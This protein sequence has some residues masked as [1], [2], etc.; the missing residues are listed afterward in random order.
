MYSG[1]FNTQTSVGLGELHIQRDQA[2]GS[3][4][5]TKKFTFPSLGVHC[6]AGA[7][8]V[9]SMR[10]YTKPSA[11]DGVFDTNIPGI[12]IRLST[13]DGPVPF[14]HY[15]DPSL[16]WSNSSGTIELIKT[17]PVT[18]SGDL[19]R[20]IIFHWGV[21]DGNNAPETYM[22][23]EWNLTSGRIIKLACALKSDSGLAFNIGDAPS[24]QF[25]SK[26][27][28][29]QQTSTVSL[30][31]DCDAEANINVT[32]T[33]TQN[34]DTTDTSVLTLSN[35]GQTGVAQGIGVQLLYNDKPLE[36]NKILVLKKSTGGVENFPI[37]ARYIQ[38]KDSITAGSANATAT[39][40]ITYQ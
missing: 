14:E 38:T 40:N 31:L 12:G 32:L 37:T 16:F 7:Y 5:T 10:L 35:Q 27:S 33:G 1:S 3:I 4:L 30:S 17:G 28:Y 18:E 13:N 23:Q 9:Y 21:G 19:S 20:G 34:P 39:L 6:D 15:S 36:L 24:E 2:V 29:S 22:V 26:G 11:V 25:I 8:S